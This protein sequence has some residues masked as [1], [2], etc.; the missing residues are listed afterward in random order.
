MDDQPS[1]Q[2][3]EVWKEGVTAQE[4]FS[5]PQIKNRAKINTGMRL[6]ANLRRKMTQL[7]HHATRYRNENS[8]M[9]RRN[10]VLIINT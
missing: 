9:M 6:K 10:K 1:G 3:K 7:I 8:S 4:R 2:S 5:L